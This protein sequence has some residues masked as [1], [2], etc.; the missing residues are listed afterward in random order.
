MRR[1]KVGE[2]NVNEAE[3]KKKG[4]ENECRGETKELGIA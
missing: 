4:N 3:K 1:K 2:S